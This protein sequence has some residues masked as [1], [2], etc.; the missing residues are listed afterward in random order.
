[1]IRRKT[2]WSRRVSNTILGGDT[3]S[4]RGFIFAEAIIPTIQ[5]L[6]VDVVGGGIERLVY[7]D[8]EPISRARRSRGGFNDYSR[9]SRDRGSSRDRFRDRDEPR[10][11]PR[12]R[13]N[14]DFDEIIIPSRAQ[15]EEVLDR[16]MDMTVRYDVATVS[17]L[18]HL[19]GITS[20]YTDERYGWSE[21]DLRRSNIARA[22]R[23]GYLLNLPRPRV[24]E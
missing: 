18:Y 21:D 16:L 11:S 14:H 6:V 13:A 3:Q 7:P 9:Y 22:G 4:V 15:A 17:N 5:N 24:L 1:M 19:V 12:G 10:M 8:S 2:P 20:S 23:E